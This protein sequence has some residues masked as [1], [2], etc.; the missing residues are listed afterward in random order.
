[1]Y[2]NCCTRF[3]WCSYVLAC[4]SVSALKVSSKSTTKVLLP[5]WSSYACQTLHGEIGASRRQS[6][7]RLARAPQRLVQLCSLLLPAHRS[8]PSS[9]PRPLAVVMPGVAYSELANWDGRF[10]STSRRN[11]PTPDLPTP[12]S[13]PTSP[14]ANTT[15][16]R[17]AN[18]PDA[19]SGDALGPRSHELASTSKELT[20]DTL[21]APA[22]MNG[23]TEKGCT[24]EKRVDGEATSLGGLGNVEDASDKVSEA[25]L[26]W[27]SVR[28][29]TCDCGQ[30][31]SGP[32]A[33][34]ER[35]SPLFTPEPE[36]LQVRGD[37]GCYT[38]RL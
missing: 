37:Y 18:T 26:V 8:H 24:E 33:V 12:G 1:M 20:A 4:V 38:P 5:I 7:L 30:R 23:P 17:V 11:T 35:S 21:P 27:A 14:R 19:V 6:R 34:P 10:S 28:D 2:Y 16:P 36:G 32:L 29:V 15:S 3:C 25:R 13:A 31:A 9:P 22:I